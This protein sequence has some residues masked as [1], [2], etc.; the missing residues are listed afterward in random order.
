MQWNMEQVYEF[1]PPFVFSSKKAKAGYA[2]SCNMITSYKITA[3]SGG[4]N[5]KINEQ[6]C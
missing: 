3:N 2:Y 4:Q 6:H 1:R 5:I